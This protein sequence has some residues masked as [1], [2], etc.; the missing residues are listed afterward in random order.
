MKKILILNY[1]YPPLWW[2][3]WVVSQ[4]YAEWLEK[5]WN[6]VTVVTTWFEWEKEFEKKWNLEIYKLKSLRKKTFQSNPIEMLSWA[7]ESIKFL[8]K[9]LKNNNFDICISFFSI[10]WWIVAKYINEKFKIP[11]IIST[12]WHDIPG[13]YPEKMKKFHILTNWYTKKIWKSTKKI[14]VLTSEMKKLADNFFKNEEKNIILPNGCYNDFFYPD[15]NKKEKKFT[16]LF[17]WR[18]VDQKDPFTMLNSIKYLNEKNVDFHVNI[19]WDGPLR[20]EME[21][22]IEQNSLKEKISVLWWLDKNELREYYQKSHIQICSSKVEAMSIAILES[23]FSGLYVFS[24]PISGNTD[25][26]EEWING[27]FFEIWDYEKL[28]EK[29]FYWSQNFAKIPFH[30]EKNEELKKIYNWESIIENLDEILQN[31]IKKND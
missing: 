26:I 3:A 13:F 7:F 20:W 21:K 1:E 29:L 4:K 6:Q 14:L 5:L 25:M 2:W 15:F 9:F 17:L 24:T 22:F 23:L 27:E 16:I 12:H 30:K 8:K 18:L 28:W 19:I 10:P 31:N 11:Y